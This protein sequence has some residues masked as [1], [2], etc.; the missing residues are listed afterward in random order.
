MKVFAEDEK[1]SY[2]PL[3]ALLKDKKVSN[4]P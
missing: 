3:I 4:P 1:V 2:H